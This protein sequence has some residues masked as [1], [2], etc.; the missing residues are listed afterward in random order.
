NLDFTDFAT[1]ARWSAWVYDNPGVDTDGDGDS[2]KCF[3]NPETKECEFW[4]EGDGIPDFAGPPP[5]DPPFL[6]FDNQEGEIRVKWNG[7]STETGVDPFTGS[8][9]FEG[10]RIWISYTGLPNDWTLLASFDYIDYKM[11]KLKPKLPG[12][13]VVWLEEGIRPN[14][15]ER[16]F[17]KYD[18]MLCVNLEQNPNYYTEFNPW[19][20]PGPDTV[21]SWYEIK[22]GDSLFFDLQDWNKGLRELRVDTTYVDFVDRVNT[23]DDSTNDIPD[24]L[25]ENKYYECGYTQTG[26]LPSFP[27]W[28]AVSAFD[29]G[30]AS[31]GLG[32][33]ESRPPINAQL[34]FALDS[35]SRVRE[36]KKKVK[37]FPNPYKIS[38]NYQL[39]EGL[40]EGSGQF[41]K[42]LNFS[43]LQGKCWIRVYTLDGD[44]VWEKYH[45]DDNDPYDYW[46]LIN[47]NTQAVVS[48][49]YLY[50]IEYDS[51][52]HQV[53]K[54]VIIK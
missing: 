2:G 54:F 46:N 43:R 40:E 53:G 8:H 41:D 23:D 45:D 44:L 22:S 30:N 42:K 3:I 15:I 50:S 9:D 13:E 31:T 11:Y 51:G 29:F 10:Y 49:I 33:L 48:G 16:Y 35:P 52:E 7:K 6:S 18:S 26:L 20:Y 14:T 25:I 39:P 36:L 28:V 17:C 1:N 12:H 21:I 19:V 24:S 5:P 27:V 32:A 4:Y 34:V 38:E 37:V 47:R